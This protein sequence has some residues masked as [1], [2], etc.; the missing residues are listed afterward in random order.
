MDWVRPSLT[1]KAGV[2]EQE[3][4]CSLNKHA[5]E[6]FSFLKPVSSAVRSS[7]SDQQYF[8]HRA[9]DKVPLPEVA[10]IRD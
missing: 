8:A 9:D 6:M 1:L 3:V 10:E 4:T 2:T 7:L 5:T